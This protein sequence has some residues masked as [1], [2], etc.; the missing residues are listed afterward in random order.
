MTGSGVG[1][2]IA[3]AAIAALAL[4]PLFLWLR[5]SLEARDDRAADNPKPSYALLTGGLAAV[6]VGILMAVN[7]VMV[8]G[9]TIGAIGTGMVVLWSVR[10]V[11]DRESV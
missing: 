3:F 6:V 2:L 9:V 10:S 11:S 5:K 7:D 4:V 1:T 8:L